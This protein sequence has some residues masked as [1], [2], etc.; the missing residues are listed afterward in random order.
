MKTTFHKDILSGAV[1]RVTDKRDGTALLR[2]VY[3]T[4]YGKVIVLHDK[5]HKNRKAAMS[6]WYR[7]TN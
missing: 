7:L 1:A 3:R 2:V 4:S 5:V 6:A